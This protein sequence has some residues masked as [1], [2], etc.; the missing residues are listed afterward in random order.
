VSEKYQR[1][2]LRDR[3]KNLTARPASRAFM[4]NYSTG[5]APTRKDA[6]DPEPEGALANGA[7]ANL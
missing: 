6:R 5:S 2:D 4:T 7:K 3:L 1:R